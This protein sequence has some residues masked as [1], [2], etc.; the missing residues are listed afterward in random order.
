MSHS[1]IHYDLF[2]LCALWSVAWQLWWFNSTLAGKVCEAVL[3]KKWKQTPLQD[4]HFEDL[5]TALALS[6][7]PMWIVQ[8]ATCRFCITAHFAFYGTLLYVWAASL[9]TSLP[10]GILI[11][12]ATS[13]LALLVYNSTK[14]VQ[15]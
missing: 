11:W 7:A 5:S 3:P 9:P 6:S 2:L 15:L 14:N 4:L 13:A 10:V 12:A 8:L 1:F